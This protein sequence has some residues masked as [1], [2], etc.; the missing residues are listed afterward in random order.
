MSEHIVKTMSGRI[1]EDPP[2]ARFLFSD[3][4]LSVLW[5]VIRVLIGY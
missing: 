5:L 1:I 3:T 4:R 2:I